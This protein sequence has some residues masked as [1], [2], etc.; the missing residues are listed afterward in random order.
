MQQ[1]LHHL[2]NLYGMASPWSPVHQCNIYDNLGKYPI[3]HIAY[4]F[5][6]LFY[7]KVECGK[8]CLARYDDGVWYK[9]TIQWVI[10]TYIPLRVYFSLQG[11]Y[12]SWKT[13]KVLKYNNLTVIYRPHHKINSAFHLLPR[14]LL[15][16]T[17]A[18]SLQT[19]QQV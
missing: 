19:K 5:L 10:I 7:S 3:I 18:K 17:W 11:S 12:W 16:Q 4:I 1:S 8:S 15:K 13:W 9:A 2:P 14:K 6:P